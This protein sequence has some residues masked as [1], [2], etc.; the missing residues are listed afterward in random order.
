M[1]PRLQEEVITNGQEAAPL[2]LG[3]LSIKEKYRL[4]VQREGKSPN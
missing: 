4:S 2:N 1:P 3:N